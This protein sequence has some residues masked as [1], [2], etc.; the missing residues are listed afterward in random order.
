MYRGG[1]FHSKPGNLRL[2]DAS[3][4]FMRLVYDRMKTTCVV[5][6]DSAGRKFVYEPEQITAIQA[7][8]NGKRLKLPSEKDLRA[9]RR[10]IQAPLPS[11]QKSHHVG[12][13]FR[14]QAL[15]EIK[16]A[17]QRLTA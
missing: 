7:R 11:L 10:T 6:F 17:V 5:L 3:P 14:S 15:C 1:R 2:S 8:G 13:D 9:P 16:P 12:A 4:A